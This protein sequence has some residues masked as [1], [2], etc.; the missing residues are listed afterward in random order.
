MQ[1]TELISNTIIKNAVFSAGDIIEGMGYTGKYGSIHLM[2]LRLQTNAIASIFHNLI[3]WRISKLTKNEWVLHH[4]GGGT[5]DLTNP[6][7]SKEIQIKT[8]SDD[9]IKGNKISKNQGH[10]ICVKY[11]VEGF[12]LFIKSILKGDLRSEDWTTS[13]KTQFAFL[14]KASELKLE[15]VFNAVYLQ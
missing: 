11:R 4:K 12:E 3:A 15:S 1:K 6:L 10:Y 8:S 13:D 5:A 2:D 7:L 14:N 9:R